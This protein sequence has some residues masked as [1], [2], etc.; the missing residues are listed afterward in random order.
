MVIAHRLSTIRQADLILVVDA[1][2]ILESG[3]HAELLARGGAYAHLYAQ[4][5]RATA[6]RPGGAGAQPAT[7][8]LAASVRWASRWAGRKCP[9]SGR[10]GRQPPTAPGRA[11]RGGSSAV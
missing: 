2:R 4:Q 1:G 5:F 9:R 3:S 6:R 10:Y 8:P 11:C 7:T